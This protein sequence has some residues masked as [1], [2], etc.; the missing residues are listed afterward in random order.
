[1]VTPAT[2]LEAWQSFF[3]HPAYHQFAS[4]ILSPERTE[5]ELTG[6]WQMVALLPGTRVLDLGCGYGRFAVPLAQADCRVCAVDGSEEQLALARS[7]ARAAKVSIDLVHR[8]LRALDYVN[9][10]DVALCLGTVLGYGEDRFADLEIL[11]GAARA[12]VPGGTLVIDTENRAPKLRASGV[13]E[14]SLSG[15]LVRSERRY[16]ASTGRWGTGAPSDRA[17][18]SLRLYSSEELSATLQRVGLRVDG[19]WG[20]L[21]GEPF[22]DAS[23]RMVIR[24][25]K[26]DEV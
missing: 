3:A 16:D 22:R 4:T 25:R 2:N 15:A 11:R 12:L 26:P 19:L 23:A 24:A 9:A 1:M 20:G 6:L 5:T 7:A 8:D 10:F 13:A 21:N 14:F 18:Y 17:A